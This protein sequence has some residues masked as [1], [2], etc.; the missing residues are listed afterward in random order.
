[1]DNHK[2]AN[3]LSHFE[4]P[5]Q[6]FEAPD[7]TIVS[8][9]GTCFSKLEADKVLKR[10]LRDAQ[11][12][13]VQTANLGA[14]II[15][16]TEASYPER[17][18]NIFDPPHLLFV[19]G[20]LPEQDTLTIA[21]VGSRTAS[22]YGKKMAAQLSKQLAAKGV[23]IVSGMARGIDGA[24]HQAAIEASGRTLG[25]LGCG[26]D[27]FYPYDTRKIREQAI[28]HGG[29]VT[30]LLPGTQPQAHI[31]PNRNRIITGISHGV[32]IVEAP[33]KSG[34]L[35]SA[36]L[37]NQQGREVFAIPG[38]IDFEGSV[39]ANRLIKQGAKMVTEVSD[40][41]EEFEHLGLT[42]Q[43]I[44]DEKSTMPVCLNEEEQA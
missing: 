14:K 36:E 42:V 8:L 12:V 26:L 40:I 19:Q 44:Q 11:N 35:I 33:E 15:T 29:I 37:A 7:A 5:Q 31:F 22:Y 9:L 17:L 13:L 16:I 10:D 25:V 28:S 1:M 34:A 24:A 38:N 4:T 30:E 27:I 18:R 39:G 21:M 23:F 20:E 32:V 2:M 6:L 43:Y 41:L 3:V